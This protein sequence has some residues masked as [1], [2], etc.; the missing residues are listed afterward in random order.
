MLQLIFISYYGTRSNS[1]DPED[2]PSVQRQRPL[3]LLDETGLFFAANLP[4]KTNSFTDEKLDFSSR[5]YEW[6][7]KHQIPSDNYAKKDDDRHYSKRRQLREEAENRVDYLSLSL[8]PP[9]RRKE[10]FLDHELSTL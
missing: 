3:S 9:S 6:Q 7:Y 1:G 5:H 2:R 8:S 10:D 4:T